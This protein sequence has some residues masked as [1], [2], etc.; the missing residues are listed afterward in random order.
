MKHCISDNSFAFYTISYIHFIFYLSKSEDV[1]R[2]ILIFFQLLS[3]S[4]GFHNPILLSINNKEFPYNII[5]NAVV[6]LS[7]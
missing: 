6:D 1:I 2:F 3:F 7:F 5:N 4:N